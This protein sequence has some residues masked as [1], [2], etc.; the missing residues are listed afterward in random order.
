MQ[1]PALA[2]LAVLVVAAQVVGHLPEQVQ[3]L[4]RLALQI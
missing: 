4:V 2:V 3:R 1:P